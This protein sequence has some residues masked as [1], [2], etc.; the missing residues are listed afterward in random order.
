MP[1]EPTQEQRS[2]VESRLKDTVE[3]VSPDHPTT[4]HELISGTGLSWLIHNGRTLLTKTLLCIM[5][6]IS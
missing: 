2:E 5:S 3:Y 4:S 6:G 1:S